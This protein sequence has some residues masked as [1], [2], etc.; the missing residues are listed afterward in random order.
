[1]DMK[2]TSMRV[3]EC[4]GPPQHFERSGP[5]EM[6]TKRLRCV[7]RSDSAAVGGAW[8][9]SARVGTSSDAQ[10]WPSV[11]LPC[12][13]QRED[14][15][16]GDPAAK[17]GHRCRLVESRSLDEAYSTGEHLATRT[18]IAMVRLCPPPPKCPFQNDR[19]T[20]RP[21]ETARG[22]EVEAGDPTE[23]VADAGRRSPRAV[24]AGQT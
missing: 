15:P 20:Q 19:V 23:R 7:R 6:I 9:G 17:A 21:S 10:R 16:K 2:D 8:H 22:E 18:R 1:M 24:A 3:D 14:C 11:A 12:E 4:L 5:C 13:G